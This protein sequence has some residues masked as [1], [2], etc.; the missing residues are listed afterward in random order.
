MQSDLSPLRVLRFSAIVSRARRPR[1]SIIG[2][3]PI[4]DISDEDL[5]DSINIPDIRARS[6]PLLPPLCS[7][8]Y[9]T[10]RREFPRTGTFVCNVL[11]LQ[12]VSGLTIYILECECVCVL[13]CMCRYIRGFYL[14]LSV[15]AVHFSS[16]ERY[17]C[18]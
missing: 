11:L 1:D 9:A 7:P 17:V 4:I 3:S 13:K 18:Y 2:F 8:D 12:C 10:V 6:P 15:S 16:Y 5:W 14:V